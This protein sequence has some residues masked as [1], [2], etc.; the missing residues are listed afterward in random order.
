[1]EW[2]DNTV[3]FESYYKNMEV[4]KQRGSIMN[5]YNS[6]NEMFSSN[7]KQDMSVFNML[8]AHTKPVDSTMYYASDTDEW[9]AESGEYFSWVDESRLDS[10][11]V[12]PATGKNFLVCMCDLDGGGYRV[13]SVTKCSDGTVYPMSVDNFSSVI[14][15]KMKDFI[16]QVKDDCVYEFYGNNFDIND[17]DYIIDS[18]DDDI[19]E[20][21]QKN[22]EQLEERLAETLN[23]CRFA[24]V[25]GAGDF[26]PGSGGVNIDWNTDDNG[27]DYR[28]F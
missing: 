5:F 9:L 20:Y 14:G 8:Y 23:R 26:M 12:T 6:F 10:G 24:Q 19:V 22:K 4:N 21:E 28:F 17:V 13:L 1:M 27:L 3:K 7:T 18:L 16:D 11:A 2:T 25:Y 15:N